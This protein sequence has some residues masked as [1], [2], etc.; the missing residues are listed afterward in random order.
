MEK[1]AEGAS[2]PLVGMETA[3]WDAG[4]GKSAQLLSGI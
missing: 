2:G 4:F 3:T 1:K